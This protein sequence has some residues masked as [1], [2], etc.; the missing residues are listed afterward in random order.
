MRALGRFARLVLA[1][2]LAGACTGAS[3][4]S[5]IT[6]AAPTSAPTAAAT[7]TA[8]PTA[9][10]AAGAAICTGTD[11]YWDKLPPVA[12]AYGLAW[13][14]RDPAP[15]LSLLE[16]GL[17]ED[18]SYVNVLLD[19]PLVGYE[20]IAANIENFQGDWTGQFFEVRAWSEGDY[21]HD[22]VRLRW[23]LCGA[24]GQSLLEGEDFLQIVPGGRI[25][26]VTGFDVEPE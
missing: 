16:E 4:S 26:E 19:E 14:E 3:P 21:H 23:R 20:A 18:A 6:P 25:R 15:R 17:E 7:A 24:D 22:R 8:I 12:Q 9:S 11:L 13:N 10:P 5:I 1:G 2:A